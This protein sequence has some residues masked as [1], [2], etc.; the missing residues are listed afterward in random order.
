MNDLPG[1]DSD[2]GNV[3]SLR[4]EDPRGHYVMRYIQHGYL[5]PDEAVTLTAIPVMQK[6]GS[7]VGKAIVGY[8]GSAASPA[9]IQYTLDTYPDRHKARQAAMQLARKMGRTYD[10][11]PLKLVRDE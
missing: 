1:M 3:P 8:N 5:D 10:P 6:D 2:H 7:W 11:T 9:M 4:I